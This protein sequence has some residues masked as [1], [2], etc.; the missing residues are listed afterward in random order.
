M[1]ETEWLACDTPGPM[2]EY[3]GSG[4]SPRKWRLVVCACCRR[5][6]D[7]LPDLSRAAVVVAEQFAD[8]ETDTTAMAAAHAAAWPV[9]TTANLMPGSAS[10]S[11]FRSALVAAVRLPV[12]VSPHAERAALRVGLDIVV[13]PR[14]EWVGRHLSITSSCKDTER[15]ASLIRD[16]RNSGPRER[17]SVLVGSVMEGV[18]HA[19]PEPSFLFKSVGHESGSASG[20][21]GLL[22]C[23]SYLV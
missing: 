4:V 11:S 9:V 1:T 14:A 12:S 13:C 6:W 18:I 17:A 2:L 8:G 21:R 20:R 7:R 22:G 10:L 15:I 5:I 23:H 16:E 3:L 19:E